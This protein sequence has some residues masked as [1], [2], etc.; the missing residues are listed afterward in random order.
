MQNLTQ[1]KIIKSKDSFKGH[2]D[3]WNINKA[4]SFVVWHASYISELH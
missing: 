4:C 2:N 3:L 1:K